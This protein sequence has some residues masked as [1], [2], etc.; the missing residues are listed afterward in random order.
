MMIH[1]MMDDTT[2]ITL[3]LMLPFMINGNEGHVLDLFL[4]LICYSR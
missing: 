1:L 2:R 4:I 3:D